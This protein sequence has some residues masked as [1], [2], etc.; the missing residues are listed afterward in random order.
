MTSS[1]NGIW[2]GSSSDN[3]NDEEQDWEMI[4]K[5]KQNK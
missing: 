4:I 3:D 5:I 2:K 1:W